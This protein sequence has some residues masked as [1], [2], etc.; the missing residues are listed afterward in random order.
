MLMEVTMGA[1]LVQVARRGFSETAR[2]RVGHR[3]ARGDGPDRPAAAVA[4]GRFADDVAE[5]AAERPEAREAD[6]EADVGDAAV[7]GPQQEHGAL[8][9]PALE[10]AVRRL[11]EGR[12]GGADEVRL[13]GVGEIGR[14]HV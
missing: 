12:A 2:S 7:G 4:R 9:A 6:V 1:T 10:V 13:R 11:A 5:R 3:E 14:A 8:D